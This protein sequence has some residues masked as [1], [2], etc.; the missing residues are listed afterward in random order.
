MTNGIRVWI[1][2]H[3]GSF[4]ESMK[5]KQMFCC[6]GMAKIAVAVMYESEDDCGAE[7]VEIT[8]QC[9]DKR[10]LSDSFLITINGDAVGHL[11]Y[12][13]EKKDD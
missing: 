13:L 10:L 1:R 5:T 8:H 9:W 6:V 12:E 2:Y 7:D 11:W 3:R 4:E